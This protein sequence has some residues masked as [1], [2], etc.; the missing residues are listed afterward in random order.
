MDVSA[1][2]TEITSLSVEERLRIVEAIWDSIEADSEDLELTPAQR[3]MLE[4]R[5]AAH[6]ANPDAVVPWEVVKAEALARI[7][8]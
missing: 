8:R 2:L 7:R 6:A 1:T 4:R 5:L 3:E